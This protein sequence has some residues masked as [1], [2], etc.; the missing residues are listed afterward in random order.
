[1]THTERKNCDKCQ[2][3]TVHLKETDEIEE[4]CLPCG[5]KN[6]EEFWKDQIKNNSFEDAKTSWEDI[7]DSDFNKEIL[8]ELTPEEKREWQKIVAK[9]NHLFKKKEGNQE[10]PTNY[11]PWIIGGGGLCLIIGM[12]IYLIYARKDN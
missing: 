4:E 7:R 5:W 11:L 12:V 8:L 2:K 3:E 10:Q 6:M 9:T 1:M